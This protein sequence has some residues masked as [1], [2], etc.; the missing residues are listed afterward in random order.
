MARRLQVVLVI[1]AVAAFGLI[2]WGI[3]VLTTPPSCASCCDD[4][5]PPG[6]SLAIGAATNTSSGGLWTY[7]FTIE[8]AASNLAL[9]DMAF[10]VR[11]PT[12]VILPF[13][14][15]CIAGPNGEALGTWSNGSW[16]TSGN[17]LPCGPAAAHPPGTTKL[18]TSD[19]LLMYIGHDSAGDS[20]VVLGTGSFSGT[21][22]ATIT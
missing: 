15:I 18:T 9:T 13:D 5:G 7:N 4:C 21:T 2:G 17:S 10:E 11:A 12:G 1:L 19:S 20:L 6:S 16:A 3:F 22:S 8:S 14:G